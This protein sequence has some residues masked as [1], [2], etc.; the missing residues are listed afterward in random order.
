M[1]HEES[2]K[3]TNLCWGQNVKGQGHE[4]QKRRKWVFAL[5]WVLAL[6][7][8]TYVYSTELIVSCYVFRQPSLV[9]AHRFHRRSSE[10]CA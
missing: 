3:P 9:S 2:W 10:S 8:L 6:S 7:T 1:F 5:L 4:S